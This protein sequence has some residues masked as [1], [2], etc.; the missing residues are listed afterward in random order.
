MYVRTYVDRELKADTH[1]WLFVG[2]LQGHDERHRRERG[3]SDRCG[4][5]PGLCR[6]P[7]HYTG[8]VPSLL[9]LA[10]TTW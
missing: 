7:G 10:S 8:I 4:R 2:L 5:Y 9:L 1:D 6:G 3:D